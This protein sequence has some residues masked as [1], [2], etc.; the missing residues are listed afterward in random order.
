MIAGD[1]PPPFVRYRAR[2]LYQMLAQK[3]RVVLLSPTVTGPACNVGIVVAL[4]VRL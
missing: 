1:L 2:R 4:D 3:V